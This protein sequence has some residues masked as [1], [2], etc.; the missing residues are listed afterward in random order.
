LPAAL[1]RFLPRFFKFRGDR[2][3]FTSGMVV[4]KFTG[5]AWLV[6][7][8]IKLLILGLGASTATTRSWSTPGAPRLPFCLTR[9]RCVPWRED[10]ALAQP[11]L[12]WSAR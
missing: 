4:T 10:Q 7:L 8:L 11:P 3:A 12:W 2:L 9:L 6:V 1:D 5:G